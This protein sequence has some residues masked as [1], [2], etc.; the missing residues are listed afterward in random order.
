MLLG[1]ESNSIF[2]LFGISMSLCS[3]IKD[4]IDPASILMNS[5]IDSELILIFSAKDYYGFLHKVLFDKQFYSL[6]CMMPHTD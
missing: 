6:Y 2:I 3:L 4:G 5:G 1:N